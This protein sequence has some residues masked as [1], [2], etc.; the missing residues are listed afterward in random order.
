MGMPLNETVSLVGNAMSTYV[1][2]SAIIAAVALI[3]LIMYIALK[4]RQNPLIF[5]VV[6]IVPL[7]VVLSEGGYLPRFI[8]GVVIV[9]AAFVMGA[10]LW[11]FFKP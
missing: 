6:F 4:Y 9:M 2:G 3:I 11:K 8:S 1:F 10:G 7:I 5:G